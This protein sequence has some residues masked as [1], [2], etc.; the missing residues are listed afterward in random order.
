MM[1]K[2]VVNLWKFSKKPL[3]TGLEL[4]DL[5]GIGK[6]K[7]T[8]A[9]KMMAEGSFEFFWTLKKTLTDGSIKYSQVRS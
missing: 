9:M 6:V 4:D 7:L 3:L 8:W 1:T 2:M 5:I